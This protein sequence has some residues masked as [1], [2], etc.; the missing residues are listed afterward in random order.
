MFMY[1]SSI[2]YEK[3]NRRAPTTAAEAKTP[4]DKKTR[5]AVQTLDAVCV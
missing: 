3:D 5:N 4:K 1:T 2:G